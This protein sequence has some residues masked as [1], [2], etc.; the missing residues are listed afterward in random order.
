[1]SS[2]E[3][4]KQYFSQQKYKFILAADAEP[5]I[6]KLKNEKII[7]EV[8]SGGVAIAL[9]PIARAA[10]ATYIARGKTEE[11]KK[12]L[13]RSQKV[14]IHRGEDTYTLKRLFVNEQDLDNYYYGFSNQTIWPLCHVAFETPEFHQVWLDGYKKVNQQFAKAIKE[15]I[16]GKTFLWIHDY[17]L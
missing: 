17:Q 2:F 3:D 7:E 4:L 10:R 14:V 9:E 8:P 13:D 5:V 1:M 6:H 11:D 12:V 16:H 15:E